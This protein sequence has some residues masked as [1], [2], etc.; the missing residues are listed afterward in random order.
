MVWK[1]YLLLRLITNHYFHARCQEKK[2]E[3]EQRS[4]DKDWLSK[5]KAKD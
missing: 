5:P 1:S 4:L 3:K 2:L